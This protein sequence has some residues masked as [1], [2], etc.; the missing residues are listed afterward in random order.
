[1]VHNLES[2]K[3]I[4]SAI[5]GVVKAILDRYNNYPEDV[6]ITVEKPEGFENVPDVELNKEKVIFILTNIKN[7][8]ESDLENYKEDVK[9]INDVLAEIEAK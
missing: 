1:M 5:I 4:A 7:E 8:L 6:V 9:Y 2:G 3:N